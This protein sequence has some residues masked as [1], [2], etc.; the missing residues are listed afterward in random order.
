MFCYQCEQ[1]THG[2]GCVKV[3][4]CGKPADV[5]DLLDDLVHAAKRL[6][7]AFA[8]TPA[9]ARPAW[10]AP[11]LEDAL[12]VTV[13]NVNFDADV[14]FARIREVVAA[15]PGTTAAERDADRETVLARAARD[16]IEARKARLGEDVT[17]L[18]ELLLYG[19]KGIAAYAH[20]AR[21]MGRTDPAVDSFMVEALAKLHGEIADI[22]ALLALE[23]RC[24]EATVAVLACLDRA[25]T[26]T[27]GVP[28][29]T[30]VT[31]GH[32]P[33]KAILVSG[34]DLVDLK[35]L[36]EQTEGTG[37]AVYTHGEMLPAHGY[38]ELKK[39]AHLVGHY[40]GAWMR[41]QREFADFPGA[42]LMTTNCLMRPFETYRG[43]LFTRNLVGW[44][45][46]GHIEDR[47]FSAVIAA[48]QAAPGFTDTVRNGEHLVGFGHQAVLGVADQVI[49]AVKSGAVK[50]FALIGGC[51]GSE[52]SRSYFTDLATAIPSDWMILTLG[53]G[54]FR[55]IGHDY[56]TVAGLP[57]LLD[58]GQC[59]DSYSAVKVAL[60][61]ADAFGCGVNELP[62]SLVLSWFEQK[63]V[64]VL[65][66][67]LHLGVKN[68][69]IGPSLPAFV[70]PAVLKV[71]VDAYALKPV[72]D[73]EA[74]L[75]AMAA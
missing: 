42:I 2:T 72:G 29:P 64:C 70:T 16:G 57:R 15:I 35:A 62:L 34:H 11:M 9:A 47:D 63:A 67:L 37:I 52:G 46:I 43:R 60:A 75:A 32:V 69:R 20:H 12:F 13:T 36:L 21:Q 23:L 26:D 40:G 3:G 61:L 8:D 44:P 39:H 33:G 18:Q 74:D 68:I 24:G 22:D 59:N 7:A 25:H 54:K 66:A 65:L 48:A 53:C 5:A 4:V 27:F 17:G 38:P 45:G 1:T 14:I 6:A 71:L 56:G 10:L 28:Q 30:P 31:M 50:H 55:V 41:Q 19:L 49:E 73:V 58:M 51:D